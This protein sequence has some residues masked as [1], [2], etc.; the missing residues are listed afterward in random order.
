MRVVAVVLLCIACAVLVGCGPSE[1]QLTRWV[2]GAVRTI[3]DT[4]T[5]VGT[6]ATA[7]ASEEIGR[8]APRMT[9]T[10]RILGFEDAGEEKVFTIRFGEGDTFWFVVREVGGE[11]RIVAIQPVDLDEGRPTL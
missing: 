5:A 3:R 8:Y 6:V 4:P 9:G 7:G 10:A 1:A 2:D 11:T